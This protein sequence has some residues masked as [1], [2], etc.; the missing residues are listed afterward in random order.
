MSIDTPYLN[1]LFV[2]LLL[3]FGSNLFAQKKDNSSFKVRTTKNSNTFVVVVGVSDYQ[4]LEIPD[5]SF[6][7]KDSQNFADFLK[8]PSWGNLKD[9]DLKLLVNEEA[10]GEVVATAIDWLYESV[11]ENDQAI[12]FFSG[13]GDEERKGRNQLGFL[14]C[15]DSG[16]NIYMAGGIYSLFYLQNMISAISIEKK[17]KVLMIA[18]ACRSGK[19]A[20]LS[21]N[22]AQL[23]AANLAPQYEN[24]VRILSCHP[25][26]FSLEGVQWRGEGR[27]AFSFHLIEG[28]IGKSDA[29]KDNLALNKY[30]KIYY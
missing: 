27:G 15:W 9:S 13:H 3:F 1:F 28:L 12:I 2:I 19:L 8:S 20:C 30:T 23:A 10:T 11:E 24:K 18:D 6:A 14:L 5:L 29:N 16:P 7:H 26:E 25:D 17:A 22:G 21:V 4:N